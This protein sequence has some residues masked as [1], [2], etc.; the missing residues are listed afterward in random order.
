MFRTT[1]RTLPTVS[2]LLLAAG[3]VAG[4]LTPPAG[5]LAP[6]MKTLDQVEARIPLG[7]ATTPGDADSVLRISQ[8]GSYYLTGNVTVPA[9]KAGIEIGSVRGITID[10]NGY[11]INGQPG[12]LAGI[13]AVDA[14]AVSRQVRIHNGRIELTGGPAIDGAFAP[15]LVVENVRVTACGGGVVASSRS[16]VRGSQF[17]DMTGKIGLALGPS[18]Q[19]SDCMFSSV[20]A[21]VV[22]GERA[23]VRDCVIDSAFDGAV[24]TGEA[25]LVE[26]LQVGGGYGVTITSASIVRDCVFN[27]V[28]R[29][30]KATAQSNHISGCVIR[31]GSLTGIEAV[32]TTTITGNT[33]SSQDGHGIIVSS[34]SIV[35]HNNVGYCNANGTWSG[36]RLTGTSNR[37]EDNV[38]TANDVGIEAADTDNFI[39]RNT[40][41]FNA[42]AFS[43]I[44]GNEFA[45]VIT[46]PGATFTN[47]TPWSNFSY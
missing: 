23:H 37:V 47:A 13:R 44:A 45:P 5:P 3:A 14:A 43:V 9:G 10:L 24:S 38:V 32:T 16:V 18:A 46:S 12:S 19:V 34:A 40:A 39:V 21:A 35:T 26:R 25:S 33:I 36:I 30:V 41:R 28:N 27:G 4:P 31:E 17:A 29:A 7:E 8:P 11:A 1:A 6:T 42:T 15:G 20:G 22:A 2:L